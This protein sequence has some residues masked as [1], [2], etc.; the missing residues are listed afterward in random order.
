M[1]ERASTPTAWSGLGPVASAMFALP[2][3][4]L[5]LMFGMK[6]PDTA[7]QLIGNWITVLPVAWACGY[8]WRLSRLAHLGVRLRRGWLLIALAL[9]SDAVGFAAFGWYEGVLGVDPTYNWVNLSFYAY[10]LLMFLGL[11]WL[12]PPS[13]TPRERPL[14]ALDVVAVGLA[15]AMLLAEFV[16]HP[17][18]DDDRT[19]HGLT[20]ILTLTMYPLLGAI[21]LFGVSSLM[22]RLPEGGERRPYQVLCAAVALYLA[23]DSTW[24]VLALLGNY[25]TGNIGDLGW[26]VGACLFLTATEMAWRGK[27]HGEFVASTYASREFT[28]MMPYLG[29]AVGMGVLLVGIVS[30][31]N[32][33]VPL[34]LMGTALAGTVFLRQWLAARNRQDQA[35]AD[36]RQSAERRLAALVARSAEAILVLGPDLRV[37]YASPG[38]ARLFSGGAPALG[39]TLVDLLHPADQQRAGRA[40]VDLCSGGPDV[41]VEWRIAHDTRDWLTCEGVLSN[42]FHDPAV[43]GLVVNLR[44]IS[45]QVALESRLR[46]Q[47]LHDPLTGVANRTLFIDRLMQA[48]VRRQRQGGSVAVLFLDLD[49]FK[50]INESL[51]HLAGDHL[52][53]SVAQRLVATVRAV[54]TVAR[55]DG[56]EFAV[57]LEDAGSHNEVV[58]AAGRILHAMAAPVLVEA[59]PAT[60]GVSLGVAFA[61][62]GDSAD[63][64]MRNAGLAVVKAKSAGRGRIAVY[65]PDMQ[66]A[67]GARLA[68]H[69]ALR[70]ALARDE[71]VLHFQ[72]LM[73]LEDGTLIGVEAL[74]RWSQDGQPM[75]A[76]DI[77]AAAEEAGLIDALGRHVLVRALHD[78]GRLA[79]E[80]DAPALLLTVNIS[81]LQLEDPD[82][83]RDLAALLAANHWPAER[84][85]LEFDE[86]IGER[87]GDNLRPVLMQLKALGL[88]LSIDNLGIG[89]AALATIERLPF[90]TLKISRQLVARLGAPNERAAR[91]LTE[92]LVGLGRTMALTTIGHGVEHARQAEA[93][94]AMG[95]R[96]AQGFHL[97]RPLPADE[98]VAWLRAAAP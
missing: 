83:V 11:L 84:L 79:A 35:L 81:V 71:F 29:V 68:L 45:E 53:R 50:L 5:L 27:R 7:R 8:A 48:L 36:T 54:D 23:A 89:D 90:D 37:G 12:T 76:N 15:G 28:R 14:Y 30:E 31:A 91:A 78:A 43:Q 6:L 25:D 61:Q 97:A 65:E 17:I 39:A 44:D 42:Q 58:G 63:T 13:R 19:P 1:A 95:C 75:A 74:L 2:L 18:L 38:T 62:E 32:D 3:L 46:R 20:E 86:R 92:A 88:R 98:L 69:Q 9:A 57:L 72:P 96:Y 52:L 94:T 26:L 87:R 22:M 59:R 85:V 10:F 60:L 82:F 64:L 66:Q 77:V 67:A 34:A 55:F 93:L 40:L 41:R 33:L 24:A 21:T 51:G 49:H 80:L 70:R 73:A 4:W 56:D 16:V 47:S